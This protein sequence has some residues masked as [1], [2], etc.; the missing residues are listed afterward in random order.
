MAQKALERIVNAGL[1][2]VVQARSGRRGH[3]VTKCKWKTWEQIK[4]D[5][6]AN[7]FRRALGLGEEDFRPIAPES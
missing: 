6:L 1:A 5:G 3:K 7:D 4:N 2:E